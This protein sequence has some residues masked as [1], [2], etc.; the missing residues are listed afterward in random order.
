MPLTKNPRP[1]P[2]T[3]PLPVDKDPG[4]EKKDKC[5][6]IFAPWIKDEDKKNKKVILDA[7]AAKLAGGAAKAGDNYCCSEQGAVN[8]GA[9]KIAG[10][11]EDIFSGTCGKEK[12][13]PSDEVTDEQR[14]KESAMEA[15][16]SKEST[17]IVGSLIKFDPLAAAGGVAQHA[18]DTKTYL[19]K[20]PNAG[21]RLGFGLGAQL[22]PPFVMPAFGLGLSMG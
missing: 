1:A 21:I 18:K 5:E 3:N 12:K 4:C 19:Q 6:W 8:R 22:M 9:A 15:Q 10:S 7:A 2:A 13:D 11:I 16:E 17:G 20:C 14:R